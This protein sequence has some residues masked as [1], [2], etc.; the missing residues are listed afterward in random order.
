MC[1]RRHSP[2]L[3]GT[4]NLKESDVESLQQNN[5]VCTTGG[6]VAGVNMIAMCF[7]AT[8]LLTYLSK[9]LS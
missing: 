6:P 9:I 2:R 7:R 4:Q 8:F 1:A 3:G 5:R